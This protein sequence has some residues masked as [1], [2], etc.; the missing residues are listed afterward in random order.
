MSIIQH[1]FNILRCNRTVN[2]SKHLIFLLQYVH[3]AWHVVIA[4]SLVCL[5]PKKCGGDTQPSSESDLSDAND[6]YSAN[7]VFVV[8]SDLNQLI[9]NQT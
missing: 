5:L 3:S 6:Y 1:N 7:P 2:V 4:L 8:M 9:P